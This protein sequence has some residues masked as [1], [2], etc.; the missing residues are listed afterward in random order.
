MNATRVVTCFTTVAILLG[1]LILAPCSQADTVNSGSISGT[2]SNFVLSGDIVDGGTRA[3]T[4]QDNTSTA[5]S[6]GAGTSDITWGGNFTPPPGTNNFSELSFTGASFSNVAPGQVFELGTLTYS[7]GSSALN[8]LIFGATFTM[9]ANLSGGGTATIT[10]FTSA[11]GLVTTTNDGPTPASNA[12]FVNFP[13]LGKSFNVIEGSSAR[14]ILF[15]EIIGDP[16][17]HLTD[18]QV[19]PDSGGTGFI[20]STPEPSTWLLLAAGLGLLLVASKRAPEVS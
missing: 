13:S 3:T 15:G 7:N 1:V 17:L 20:A 12:D 2:F 4:F 10:P 9:T 6:S 11:L 18:V 5:I 14:A 8:S 16:S 19:A